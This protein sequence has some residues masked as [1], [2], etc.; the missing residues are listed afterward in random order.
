MAYRAGRST[1]PFGREAPPELFRTLLRAARELGASDLHLV[2]GRPPLMRVGGQI[3]AQ[4]DALDGTLVKDMVLPRVPGRLDAILARDGSCDFAIEEGELGRY[5]INV[6][7]QRTG[8][9]ASLRLVSLQVPTLQS[10]G[11]PLAIGAATH[12]HQG[13]IVLTGPTGHGKTTTLAAV[14]DILNAE[15]ARHVITVED[16]IEYIHPRKRAMMS[17]REVGT[18][19]RS[20][21]SALKAA[22]REDPDVIVIGELRDTETVRIALEASETGHLV[23][24]TMSTP[25]ASKAIDRLINLFPPAISSRCG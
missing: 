1:R 8:L 17:Q 11:L 10:L 9:K 16:P 12:H 22:L 19:T 21:H 13:L 4:G 24:G 23:L 20:F 18:H 14:V 25:S 15:S 7:R 3:V 5:R 2:S 6:S